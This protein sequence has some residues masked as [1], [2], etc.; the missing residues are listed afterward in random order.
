[1]KAIKV[2]GFKC[3]LQRD[4]LVVVFPQALISFVGCK[5]MLGGLWSAKFKCGMPQ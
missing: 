3:G 5:E 1:M 2:M 4:D